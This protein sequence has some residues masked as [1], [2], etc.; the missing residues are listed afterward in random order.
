MTQSKEKCCPKCKGKLVILDIQPS[1]DKLV[2]PLLRIGY[3]Y[4][5]KKCGRQYEIKALTNF[6]SSNFIPNSEVE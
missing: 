6:I 3:R 5:C 2:H 4:S 1:E